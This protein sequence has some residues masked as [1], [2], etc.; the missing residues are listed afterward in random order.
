MVAC[1]PARYHKQLGGAQ[2]EALDGQHPGVSRCPSAGEVFGGEWERGRTSLS[3]PHGHRA[4]LCQK[5]THNHP[6]PYLLC[7]PGLVQALLLGLVDATTPSHAHLGYWGGV[8]E[9]E[10][11]P[12]MWKIEVHKDQL[13]LSCLGFS[14]V[15]AAPYEDLNRLKFRSMLHC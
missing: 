11:L 6:H 14:P 15:S 2:G 1:P 3:L 7:K 8:P 4:S 5:R 12:Q 10:P 13:L 9:T